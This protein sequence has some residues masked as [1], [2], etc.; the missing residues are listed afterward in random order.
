MQPKLL[1]SLYSQVTPL[2]P[3][4]VF[5]P[6]SHPCQTIS[7]AHRWSLHCPGHTLSHTLAWGFAQILPLLLCDSELKLVCLIMQHVGPPRDGIYGYAACR[8]LPEMPFL[9]S[10]LS[11][12]HSVVYCCQLLWYRQW[13]L[14]PW[15]FLSPPAVP[16]DKDA[17]LP[18][19]QVQHHLSLYTGL[20]VPFSGKHWLAFLLYFWVA[21]WLVNSSLC[22]LYIPL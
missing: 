1:Q 9:G 19:L 8:A 17:F 22:F 6:F 12:S 14:C 21:M 18:G 15:Y 4:S 11:C 7:T 5:K 3:S 10:L 16:I 20:R 13:P 2:Q